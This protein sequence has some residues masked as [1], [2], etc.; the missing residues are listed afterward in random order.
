MSVILDPLI[1]KSDSYQISYIKKVLNKIK[2]SDDG[3]AAAAAG[4]VLAS[5]TQ[6]P[7]S[8]NLNKSIFHNLYSLNK[9][10]KN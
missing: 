1:E 10:L 7:G 8:N 3:L 4:S 9:V 6:V 2:I 5:S